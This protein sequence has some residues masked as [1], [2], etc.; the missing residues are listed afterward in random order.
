MKTISFYCLSFCFFF[1]ILLIGQDS[2]I[3][4]RKNM[5]NSKEAAIA[6]FENGQYEKAIYA[7]CNLLKEDPEDF[8]LYG[9]R[10]VAF[11][12]NGQPSLALADLNMAISK[13]P[14]AIYYFY[15]ASLLPYSDLKGKIANYD[16][17]ISLESGNARYFYERASLKLRAFREYVYDKPEDERLEM[18]ALEKRL[19]FSM[20]ICKDF[21][22]ATALDK[23]YAHKAFQ[24][25]NAFEDLK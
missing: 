11:L 2:F 1:P 17:A 24:H 18:K 23:D 25:C 3:P 6:L 10:G 20:T 7:F 13:K 22:M 16:M 4:D 19:G 12:W 14:E 15:R 21:N 5:D 9:K 8:E